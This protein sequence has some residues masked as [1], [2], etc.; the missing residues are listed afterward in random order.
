MTDNAKFIPSAAIIQAELVDWL[1]SNC[2]LVQNGFIP[3]YHAVLGDPPYFLGSIVK[4]FGKNNAIPAGYGKD[5]AFSRQTRGFMG[6]TWDGFDS[7]DSY[8][9]WVT[10]W[11][12]LLL[13]YVYPGAVLAM[14]G[15]TRTY[16]RLVCGLE[17]AGWQVQDCLMYMY[18]S[19]FPKSHNLSG[20]YGTALKPAYEP[21][22]LAR[23][24]RGKFTYA[25]LVRQ[26]GAGGL[27]I[28]RCRIE[29]GKDYQPSAAGRW[30][31]NIIFDDKAASLLDFQAGKRDAGS[32]KTGNEPSA[33]TLHVYGKMRRVS[34]EGYGDS[35]GASRFFYTAK[36]A[37]WERDAGLSEF[38]ETQI[39]STYDTE[40]RAKNG[41]DSGHPR[42][43]FHPT[44]K[45]IQ[46]TEWLA[47][48]LLP[49]ASDQTRR[50]LVTFAGVASE[51]IGAH[52]AGW[53]E[54]DGIEQSDEYTAIGL[55]RL[56][57]WQKHRNY[58]QAQSAYIGENQDKNLEGLGQLPLF[59]SGDA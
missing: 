35:G 40:T 53:D 6:Q 29:A 3:R 11:A 31:S 32:R 50:L 20:G 21:I 24:P 44:V 10:E 36:A 43:N 12:T 16:H 48:L 14:F 18:G 15:G 57:W 46:L 2:W 55:A 22:V 1:R 34:W 39:R 4:R 30:P 41:N 59:N 51:M 54:I 17:N 23:A 42:K 5:G 38:T 9:A 33:Q 28:D 25:D 49:P 58:R 19:G 37:S 47:R 13:N 27:N 45:P 56:A 8:Q 52:L 26:F 7:L